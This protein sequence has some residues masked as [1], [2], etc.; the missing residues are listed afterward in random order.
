MKSLKKKI[1]LA[2]STALVGTLPGVAS[3]TACMSQWIDWAAAGPNGAVIAGGM[4]GIAA[5]EDGGRTWSARTPVT[6]NTD[7]EAIIAGGS[8]YLSTRSGFYVSDDLGRSWQELG[9]QHG[10]AVD[11]SGLVYAC[12]AEGGTVE[13]LDAQRHW[14]ELPILD[15]RRTEWEVSLREDGRADSSEL[16]YD[17]NGRKTVRKGGPL[18]MD[19]SPRSA[20]CERIIAAGHTLAVFSRQAVFVSKDRGKHWTGLLFDKALSGTDPVD[21]HQAGMQLDGHD[22]LYVDRRRNQE[23]LVMRSRDGGK[24]WGEMPGS[25]G[26]TVI[27]ADG[28]GIYLALASDFRVSSPNSIFRQDQGGPLERILSLPAVS[29]FYNAAHLLQAGGKAPALLTMREQLVLQDPDGAWR[30][31]DGQVMTTTPWTWC[32]PPPGRKFSSTDDDQPLALCD[33]KPDGQRRGGKPG[34]VPALP[35][36]NRARSRR[37]AR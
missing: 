35:A 6:S 22:V 16:R 11:D 24:T 23:R 1:A 2:V 31:I 32:T 4:F 14:Q 10:I 17:I 18:V 8:V 12:S 25:R 26:Y 34:S 27:G 7:G 36:R 33:F 37:K 21:F 20:S 15:Q 19:T 30:T 3:A 28:K 9:K 13:V 29:V 5:S